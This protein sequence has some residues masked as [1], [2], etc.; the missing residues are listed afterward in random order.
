MERMIAAMKQLAASQK[1]MAASIAAITDLRE[2]VDTPEQEPPTPNAISTVN[3][4]ALADN[5][6]APSASRGGDLGIH[7]SYNF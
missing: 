4:G 2:A 3:G 6:A 5:D 7:G 1:Q